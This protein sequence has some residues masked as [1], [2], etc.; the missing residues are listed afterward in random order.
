[1][2][3]CFFLQNFG[4]ESSF[5]TL[6]KL[7]LHVDEFYRFLFPSVPN[8]PDNHI[9]RSIIVLPTNGVFN[10]GTPTLTGIQK[11]SPPFFLIAQNFAKTTVLVD[12]NTLSCVAIL[13]NG[14]N[15]GNGRFEVVERF[16]HSFRVAPNQVLSFRIEDRFGALI[17][18]DSSSFFMI[19]L[20]Q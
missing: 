15:N 11:Y 10:F 4:L 9:G 1:M 8:G 20:F 14:N 7:S 6:V 3:E 19:K 13:D 2:G 12:D 16:E 17:H 18:C 5:A